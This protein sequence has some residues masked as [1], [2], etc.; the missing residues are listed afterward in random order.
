MITGK[1]A[2]EIF[3]AICA[4]HRAMTI[5]VV[6]AAGLP[7][8]APVYY[9]YQYRDN[10]KAFYFLSSPRSRHLEALQKEASLQASVAI[11]NEPE[12]YEEIRGLQMSGIIEEISSLQE[13]AKLLLA[14]GKRFSFFDK[15]L[16]Q[17]VLIKEL[18]KN[19][20]Y[21]FIPQS[22]FIVHNEVSFGQRI[23]L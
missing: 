15:F 13:R 10:E 23:T 4:E 20:L 22:I 9:L 8:S 21:R 7:W 16:A 2:E 19:K 11:Y 3:E 12:A 18:E 5:A 17:P 1:E 6:D 14:F